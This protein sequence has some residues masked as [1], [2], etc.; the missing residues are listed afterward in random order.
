MNLLNMDKQFTSL[1]V[2]RMC[3]TQSTNFE[4]QTTFDGIA[5]QTEKIMDG[6]GCAGEDELA[7]VFLQ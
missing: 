5:A 4:P 7:A 6:C 1:A 2:E 3:T